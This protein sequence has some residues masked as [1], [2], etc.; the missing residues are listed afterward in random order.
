MKLIADLG[1]RKLI[2][3]IDCLLMIQLYNSIES[4]H[5]CS[6]VAVLVTDIQDLMKS[7]EICKLQ[8]VYWE[9]NI[10]V[11]LL[12]CHAWHLDSFLLWESSPNFVKQV[13]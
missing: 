12:A 9:Y 3:K 4:V 1:I 2:I 11:H 8:H 5:T 10:P 13:I 6:K 7:I